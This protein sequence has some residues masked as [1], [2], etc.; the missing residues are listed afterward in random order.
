MIRISCVIKCINF[1]YLK[2]SNVA[3]LILMRHAK[4][5]WSENAADYERALN[6]RGRKSCLTLRAWF[7]DNNI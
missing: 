5:D 4:S 1:P 2:R 6:K 7:L 3:N